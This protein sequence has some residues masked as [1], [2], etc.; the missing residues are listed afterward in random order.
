MVGLGAPPLQGH[1]AAWQGEPDK[2]EHRDGEQAR[3]VRLRQNPAGSH[4][5]GALHLP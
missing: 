5:Q 4:P 3:A 2:P 1:L